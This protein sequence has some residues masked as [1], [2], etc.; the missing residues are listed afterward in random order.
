M[1]VLVFP[2][3][4]F[5]RGIPTECGFE[6]GC[7]ISWGGES[8]FRISFSSRAGQDLGAKGYVRVQADQ[9][10]EVLTSW[11]QVSDKLSTSGLT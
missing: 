1:Q 7:D 8:V 4:W 11:P 3:A 9:S 2:E 10:R 5:S 6:T